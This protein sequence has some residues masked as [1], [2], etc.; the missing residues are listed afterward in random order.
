MILLVLESLSEVQE[1]EFQ[2]SRDKR[3]KISTMNND[4]KI[5]KFNQKGNFKQNMNHYLFVNFQ[6]QPRRKENLF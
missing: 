3:E 4:N 6:T 1:I 2:S 5:S